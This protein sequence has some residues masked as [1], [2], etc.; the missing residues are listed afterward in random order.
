MCARF[1]LTSPIE[2]VRNLFKLNESPNLR[3]SY[4]IAPT[5]SVFAVRAPEYPDENLRYFMPQWGLIPTWAKD[6]SIAAKLINARS[7]TVSEKP[8]FR[9]AFK[10]RRCLIPASGFFEWKKTEDGTKQPYYIQAENQPIFSFAG[11][12]ENWTATDGTI[13]ESC[14]LLTQAATSE[15][16]SIHSRMPV[17]VN[18]DYHENWLVG[19]DNSSLPPHNSQAVFTAYPV[20]KRV[21]NVRENDADL[22]KRI[23]ISDTPIQR[24]LF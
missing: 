21:G 14:T 4:N 10:S 15:F 16:E 5:N 24:S 19:S 1:S 13:I 12:W 11:L 23:E 20:N 17:T 22:I 7:E 8:S 18:P 9:S 3:A 6:K 2:A